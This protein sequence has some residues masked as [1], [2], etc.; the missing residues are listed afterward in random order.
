MAGSYLFVEH[1]MPR[2]SQMMRIA[3]ECQVS[4]DTAFAAWFRLWCWF[5]ISTTDGHM[6]FLTPDM[7]DDVGCVPGL[8]AA[9]VKV[10]WVKF[11]DEG[12]VVCYWNRHFG[13]S[14]RK[15]AARYRR[16][17]MNKARRAERMAQD[18]NAK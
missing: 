17:E 12:G 5:D 2:K 16:L 10:G 15:R 13:V 14:A 6:R 7:C 18:Q 8:G 1:S 9:L 4:M 11:I 3:R